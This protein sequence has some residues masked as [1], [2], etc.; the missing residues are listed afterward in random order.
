MSQQ[1]QPRRP[2][3]P[4]KYGDV[5]E[6]SGELADKTIAPED[7]NMMQ[8]AETR[9]F[10]HTQKGGTAAVMQSAATANKRG[11]FVQQGDATDVAAE[12]GVTVAQTDVPGARV[13]TEFVGGQ[14]VGQY[15]E[16]VPVGT[17]AATDAE[18]LG[19]NLQSAITIGEAL[20]AAVQTAGNKPVDQSDAAA[21]QAAEVRASGTSDIAPGGIAASARS[22]ANHN[23]TVDRDED[24]I[25]LV[26][27]L[28]GATGKLQADKAVTRQD[29]EGVVSAE[30]RNNPYLTIHPG[31]VAASVTAAARLNEK[32]DI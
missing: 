6:V 30:L 29:A 28:A 26:D 32:A 9:V 5:F 4:V 14:V 16:P 25:K 8:A 22:A 27:V 12:H 23:A 3:E 24:K 7:A 31:G 21:I 13:T 19:L 11:G 2:Q 20:E 10:G 15:V 18:T 1:E 17:T